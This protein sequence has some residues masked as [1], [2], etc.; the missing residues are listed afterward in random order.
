M[1]Y[2]Y[3]VCELNGFEFWGTLKECQIYIS[4]N[5]FQDSLFTIERA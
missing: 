5:Q 1:E 2:I 4:E 3:I